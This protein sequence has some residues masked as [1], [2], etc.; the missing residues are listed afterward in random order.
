MRCGC[1]GLAATAQ[2]AIDVN[3]FG[4]FLIILNPKLKAVSIFTKLVPARCKPLTSFLFQLPLFAPILHAKNLLV[5]NPIAYVSALACTN[6][7][8]SNVGLPQGIQ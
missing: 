1:D 2:M 5:D 4:G 8:Q 3:L 6:L 7:T